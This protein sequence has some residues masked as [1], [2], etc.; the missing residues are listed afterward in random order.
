M[1]LLDIK[2]CSRYCHQWQRRE[3]NTQSKTEIESL[4]SWDRTTN[5]KV[6]MSREMIG[7]TNCQQDV[8]RA[9]EGQL[10]KATAE[11]ILVPSSNVFSVS[12]QL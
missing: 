5:S 9:G 12:T 4:R 1:H 2:I 11:I 8:G 10:F 6:G 7:T 3:K